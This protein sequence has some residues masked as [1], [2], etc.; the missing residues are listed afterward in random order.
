MSSEEESDDELDGSMFGDL[1]TT[2]HDK[3]WRQK[4][5]YDAMRQRRMAVCYFFTQIYGSP[6]ESS[7]LWDGRKGIVTK[8]CEHLCIQ[9]ESDLTPIRKWLRLIMLYQ[10][11]DEKYT[12]EAEP[13]K[14]WENY[15]IPLDSTDAQLAADMIEEEFGFS[16]TTHFL[17]MLHEDEGRFAVGCSCMYDTV[18]RMKPTVTTIKKRQQGSGNINSNWAIAN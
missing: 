14:Q 5:S 18:K 1:L 15:F 9:P 2:D 16:E 8:T 4:T 17:N 3:F 11:K 10:E 7:G 13:R 12:G 6:P